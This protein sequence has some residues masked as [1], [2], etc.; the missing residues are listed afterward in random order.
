MT[1]DVVLIIA[2]WLRVAFVE[3]HIHPGTQC[4]MMHGTC[5]RC[6]IQFY[7]DYLST[8]GNC[9]CSGPVRYDSPMFFDELEFA[10]SSVL[11]KV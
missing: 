2:D 6:C 11:V 1:N 9:K 8:F 4:I 10:V 7:D 3:Y 5:N